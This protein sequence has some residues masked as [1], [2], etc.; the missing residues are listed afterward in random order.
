MNGDGL[1]GND[2]MY[3]PR[4]TTEMNFQ[5][6]TS[7]GS[8]NTYT[9][10]QQAAAFDAFINQDSYLR[11]NRGK[12]AERNGVNLPMVTRFDLSAM[13]ELFR[14]I[15]KQRHTIQLRADIFNIGNMINSKWGVGY[16]V[17]NFNPLQAVGYTPSTGVPLF[18]MAEVNN[19]L[20]YSTYRRGTG[21]IDVW[22]AQFGIRYIF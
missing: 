15:G 17:N 2:L 7:S 1:A 3:I 5:Q 6:Y 22:Q 18:R 8:G 13:L 21:L 19:S 14:N 20:N 12:I 9:A 4:N 11:K 10:A 16:V